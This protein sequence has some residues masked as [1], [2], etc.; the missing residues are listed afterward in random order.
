MARAR[1][2]EEGPVLLAE[3]DLTV[4]AEAGDQSETEVVERLV[5]ERV[6]WSIKCGV[7]HC[8]SAYGLH[9]PTLAGGDGACDPALASTPGACRR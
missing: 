6:V 3:R 8:P 5:E 2:L 9:G 1:D 7:L 4:V